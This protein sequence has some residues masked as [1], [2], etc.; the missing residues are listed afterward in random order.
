M[1]L[2][3]TQLHYVSNIIPFLEWLNSPSRG[4]NTPCTLHRTSWWQD[5]L[6]SRRKTLVTMF[7]FYKGIHIDICFIQGSKTMIIFD[8]TCYEKKTRN[9]QYIEE[10]D[11]LWQRN[12]ILFDKCWYRLRLKVKDDTW[13]FFVTN[14]EHSHELERNP[15]SLKQNRNKDSNR[16]IA[17]QQVEYLCRAEIKYR[18]ALPAL[19]IQ[20]LRLSKND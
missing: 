8:S 17:I 4:T 5:F 15:F 18:Q 19:N 6:I 10:E 1:K 7:C 11:R 9:T 12:N 16:F 3:V 20:G 14:V 2:I 13:Q